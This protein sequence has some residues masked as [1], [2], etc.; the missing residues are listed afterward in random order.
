MTDD[1]TV[2]GALRDP[3]YWFEIGDL[4]NYMLGGSSP[5]GIQRIMLELLPRLEALAGGGGRFQFCRNDGR[6]GRL[7]PV[8]LETLLTAYA[9]PMPCG[10]LWPPSWWWRKGYQSL[11]APPPPVRPGDALVVLGLPWFIHH[12]NRR[13]GDLKSRYG[14][15]VAALIHDLI[16]LTHPDVVTGGVIK[17]F[18]SWIDGAIANADLLLT[19]S[20]YSAMSLREVAVDRGWTLP[21]IARLRFGAEAFAETPPRRRH[22]SQPVTGLSRFVL[23]VATFER[24]KNHRLL[25]EIW[26]ALCAKHGAA[27]VPDLVLVGKRQGLIDKVFDE[28]LRRTN[29]LDGKIRVLTDLDDAVLRDLYDRCAFTVFPS[30]VE[31]WGLPV[32]ESLSHGKLCLASDR[33]SIPEVGGDL[34]CYFDPDDVDG[35]VALIER[36]I[37]DDG[38]R[39]RQ[40]QRI[41]ATFRPPSWSDCAKSLVEI[42]DARFRPVMPG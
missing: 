6:G 32:A 3:V 21:P 26:Q 2:D 10:S 18:S 34:V 39:T 23:Y 38:W 25:F 42:L 22:K 12:H 28:N 29:A 14:M 11:R 5:T 24:R 17:A 1:P 41:R 13:V 4:L 27:A 37:V 31:G 19:V 35:A 7:V 20:D 15:K 36:A 8:S 30:L 40:E 9:N 16:P 33:T